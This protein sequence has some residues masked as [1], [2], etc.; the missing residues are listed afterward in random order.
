MFTTSSIF[1]DSS[2]LIEAEKG[3]RP[4]LFAALSD[5]PPERLAVNSI[6]W[7]EFLFHYLAVGTNVSPRTVKE[8]GEIGNVLRKSTRYELIC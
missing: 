4:E 8:R 7:S 2:V 6:V 1:V 3:T 5:L